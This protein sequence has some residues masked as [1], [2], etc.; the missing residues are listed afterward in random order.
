MFILVHWNYLRLCRYW[1]IGIA[2]HSSSSLKKD[3]AIQTEA[4]AVYSSSS[5]GNYYQV[6]NIII[7]R[8]QKIK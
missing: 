3:T 8:L 4:T 1:Y 2:F 7:C 6:S 5:I